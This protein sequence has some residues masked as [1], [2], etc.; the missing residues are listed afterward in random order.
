[1]I[2]SLLLPL[3]VPLPHAACEAVDTFI[4]EECTV[5][6]YVPLWGVFPME[7]KGVGVNGTKLRRFRMHFFVASF[8]V[9]R[10]AIPWR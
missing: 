3:V 4:D 9:A 5:P 1:M 10:H 2:H 8:V 7:G 6:P